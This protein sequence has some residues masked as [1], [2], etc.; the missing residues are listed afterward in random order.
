MPWSWIEVAELTRNISLESEE[1]IVNLKRMSLKKNSGR[2]SWYF[3]FLAYLSND[4][5]IDLE[6][7]STIN[8]KN[9][10]KYPVEKA[11]GRVIKN[12]MNQIDEF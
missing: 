12:T 8:Y 10:L 9:N 2:V 4:L 6:K 1:E 5:G 3:H 7:R 11:K